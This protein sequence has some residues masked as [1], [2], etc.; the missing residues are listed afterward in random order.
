MAS[1]NVKSTRQRLQD[2]KFHEL[3]IE[4]LGWSQPA[5]TR[6]E[7]FDLS[8]L[9]FSRAQIAH[10]GG[11]AVFEVTSTNG[12]I[13][14]SQIRKEI[15]KDITGSYHENLLIFIDQR[16][17]QS[18]WYWIKREQGK[19]YVREHYYF[20]GQP[21]DL[22]LSK[23]SSMVVD[24]G[25]LDE[26]GNI[27]VTEAVDRLK[28]ALDV[29]RVIKRFY[30]E[31]TAQRLAF[32]DLITGIKDE[33]EQRWYASII[34][35]RLMFIYFLQGKGF[36]DKRSGADHGDFFYLQNKLVE[37]REKYGKDKFFSVF[38]QAL[39]FEGFAKPENNRADKVKQLLG[40]IKYLNGGL[41]LKHRIEDNNEIDIPDE[42]FENLL[43]LFKSYSWN[44]DDTPGGSDDDMNP[45]VL[46]YIFEKYI[47]QKAFGAYYTRPEQTEYLC[48]RTIYKLVLDRVNSKGVPGVIEPVNFKSIAELLMNLN[49]ALCRQ[50][51]YDILPNLSIL[52]PACGSGAFLV[53]AMKTL[54][55]LYSA[56][57]G[58][59]EFL[60]DINLKNWLAD[61]HKKHPS[62]NYYIKKSIITYNLY[63]VDIMEEA[64]EIAKLR[65]FLSLVASAS[66]IDELEPLP[67]IDFNIMAGNSL[68]GLLNVDEKTFEES[69]D[70]VTQSYY[71][72]YAERLGERNRLLSTY[73]DASTYAEDLR[74][75][76]D[77]I[78]KKSAEVRNTLDHL[79]LDQFGTLGI[80]YH[81]AI[82][83]EK[84][85][86]EGKPKRRALEIQDIE[87]LKPF[88]WG[89]EFSEIM[90]NK[91]GFDAVVTNPPWEVF[92][93][94]EKEFFQEYSDTI[95]KKKLRIEDWEKQR[96]KLMKDSEIK[97]AWLNYSSAFPHQWDFFKQTQQYSNQI[98][99]IDGKGV[100]NKLNLCNL[101]LEQCYNLL[102]NCGECGIVIPSGIYTDLGT[103]QL[104]EML[105]E[106][107]LVTGLFGFENRKE[108]F[109]NV[110]SRFKFVVLTFEKGSTTESFPAKFMRHDVSELEAFPQDDALRID[111]NFVKQISPDSFSIPEFKNA[112]EIAILKKAIK[113]PLLSNSKEGWGIELYGEE[114]NMTRSASS[115]KTKD[116]GY[117]VYE[118]GMIWHFDN[119]FAEPR[120]WVQ[121]KLLR[122]EFLLKRI[123]RIQGLDS[124]PKDMKNDYEAYRLAIRKIAS[125]TNERTLITS[126]IRPFVFAG[127]S[128]TVHFPYLQTKEEYS[129][130][131]YTHAELLCLTAI[132]NS[133]ILDQILRSRM[134]TNLNLFYL[135][136]LPVP[137]LTKTDK[138]FSSIVSRAARLICTTPEFDDLAAE[139][140]LGSHKNGATDPAERAQLRAELDGIIAH[141]YELTEDE[142]TYILTTF[143]IVAQSVKDAAL[144]QYRAFAPRSADAEV[145]ALIKARENH[146]VEFKESARWDV[147]LNQQNKAIEKVIRDTVAAF[148]N[149]D[150]GTLLIGVSDDGIITG[151]KS[152][153]K[154]FGTKNARDA[155]ENW[156]MQLILIHCGKDIA[157]CIKITFHD[158][159]G[160]DVCRVNISPS[161]RAVFVQE[162]NIEQFF[163]RTG[164]SKKQ[165]STSEVL[166]Y[167]K[168]KWLT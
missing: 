126:I 161:P 153:Y 90:E 127:N 64:T 103:K 33:R 94:N 133:Y 134:T 58:R 70:L 62:I 51:L 79:L 92:Q 159:N 47:N 32:T 40:N 118:G 93:T 119:N 6:V 112:T 84:K 124:V 131:C 104:R 144:E 66:S 95:Q 63:G 87:Q 163:I 148:L 99:L 97:V 155:Y 30:R 43:A 67:N 46:G 139:V 3:F 27:H 2:F 45:E 146:L 108:I 1:L 38:L 101:F 76:R 116:T 44:L 53:A 25:D 166:Q 10:L 122:K 35:N 23:L 77:N 59:I 110:D 138:V 129:T 18:L 135:Y 115:F 152:D 37:C 106:K 5:K 74:A 143:P 150:G 31:Y 12:V 149:S 117:P 48:E 89:F 132:L 109:E 105:F 111:I 154:L 113:F 140:G 157:P 60:N 80:S 8:G 26:N 78:E 68:I 21:G 16:R 81:E 54:I 9:R 121:E 72:T 130:E 57:I 136:Q 14:P 151:L 20:R 24:I 56:V 128:L 125:N 123:K 114:L 100:G 11:V 22:F 120:Y 65:L 96:D 164:N 19:Q 55:N 98:T 147:K 4:E 42:A 91:G 75:L 49:A 83:D 107:T 158:L 167:C 168:Q 15:Q 61:I 86:K 88:H 156:L 7:H 85:N 13:P 71:H 73:R 165:L 69:L 137:R 50:L 29:E 39:F 141:L 82:W 28:K 145:L 52:D 17:T 41:F 34:L 142:F 160:T 102:K 162:G 36:L